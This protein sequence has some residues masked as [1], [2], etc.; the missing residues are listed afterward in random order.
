MTYS[1]A[2]REWAEKWD[3]C[4]LCGKRGAWQVGTLVIHHLVRG[5]FRDADHLATTAIACP[6]CHHEEHN[7]DSLGYIGW[8]VLKRHYDRENY[9]LAA[10]CKARGRAFTSLSE[11]LIDAVE[12]SLAEEGRLPYVP[13]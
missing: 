9:N 13:T 5:A 12:R 11:E 3:A 7:G 10:V 4:W 1:D 6:S 8:L 2:T